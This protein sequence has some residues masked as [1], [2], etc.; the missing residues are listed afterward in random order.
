M[1]SG[2]GTGNRG[3]ERSPGTVTV[4]RL[5]THLHTPTSWPGG[6]V[7]LRA[8]DG[9]EERER[10]GKVR[11]ERGAER[12]REK[13]VKRNKGGREKERERNKKK[14]KKGKVDIRNRRKE[15]I[16]GKK[17]RGWR[18]TKIGKEKKT[19]RKVKRER[20]GGGE[21]DRYHRMPRK[22]PERA[23]VHPVS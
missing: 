13:T 4:H 3:T 8:D 15:K 2:R 9:A 12:E 17:E 22:P 6:P 20:R 1:R 18:G 10:K 23:R 14:C 19:K 11:Q 21:T 16:E 7:L 5:D